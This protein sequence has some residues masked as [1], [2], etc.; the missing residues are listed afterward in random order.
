[1]SDPSVPMADRGTYRG[2][3][4]KAA[5]LADLGVT[6]IELQPIH[7]TQNDMN[8]AA[9]AAMTTN[10]MNYWGYSSL[11]YFAPDRRY[12]ADKSPGGPTREFVAM[13][14]A[15]HAAGIKVFLDVVYNHTGEGGISKTDPS[16]ARLLSWRG[17]DAAYYEL[18][19]DSQ[20]SVDFTGVGHTF[21]TAAKASRDLVIDSLLYWKSLGV[22]GFR[23]DLA[24]IL[25]NACATACFRFDAADKA[26]ALNRA[27]AELPARPA[28]GGDGVDLIAEPWAIGNGTYQL[29]SFPAGWSEWNGNFRDTI[30]RAQNELG[31]V[32][33]TPAT[34]ASRFGGSP[35]VFVGRKPQASIDYVASHDGFTLR[36]VYTYDAKNNAQPWP[37]GPSP[38]GDDNNDSWSQGGD[39]IAQR[40][41]ARTALTIALVSA[42]VPMITGG[43]E[44]FRTQHGN[45]NAYNLDT[46]ANWLDWT[47]LASESDFFAYARRAFRFRA[48]HPAL[49]PAAFRAGIDHD[50]N[51]LKDVT[52]L[53]ASGAEADA[54]YMA[55]ASQ[56]FIAFRIDGSEGGDS[57][58]SIYVAY[59]AWSA[60]VVATLPAALGAWALAADSGAGTFADVGQE[61]P[62]GAATYTVSARAMVVLVD[63]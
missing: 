50:H 58:R 48:A 15:F 8:D 46:S 10:G 4:T 14:A 12:A 16:I 26:N 11:A 1:M 20:T 9:A 19:A 7:E 29:G 2:A 54:N 35:D 31:V 42:G 40:R 59:N 57:A 27:V 33:T 6:A 51:G 60:N 44:F 43:D 47:N 53:R 22:D 63:R 28:S 38:G 36:D 23:F 30:R 52:W 37:F 32:A 34:L 41:A 13:V 25:G 62:V 55:D 5:Y 56:H 61:T 17:L 49:R 3:A 45:N 24:P 18:S 21:N 39:P